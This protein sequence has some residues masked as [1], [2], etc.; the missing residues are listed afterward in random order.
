MI[1]F[2]RIGSRL[3]QKVRLAL[4]EKIRLEITYEGDEYKDGLIDAGVFAGSLISFDSAIKEANRVLNGEDS[5]IVTKVNADFEKKCFKVE[6][7]LAFTFLA[8]AR[9]LLGLDSHTPLQQV[10][11]AVGFIKNVANSNLGANLISGY[12]AY[13]LW[14]GGRTP[15]SVIKKEN[16]NM[17]ISFGEERKEVDVKVWFLE[18]KSKTFKKYFYKHIEAP[19]DLKYNVANDPE[20]VSITAKEKTNFRSES[21][22]DT[23]PPVVLTQRVELVVAAYDRKYKWRFFDGESTFTANIEDQIFWTSRVDK[24]EKWGKGDFFTVQM[25][26]EQFMENGQL[27][28]NNVIEKVIDTQSGSP[29]LS[30][31]IEP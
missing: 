29:L 25:R 7:E 31:H 22:D 20:G 15:T 27:K 21:I 14:S 16:G 3:V 2:R 30:D 24:G 17:E 11:S 6:L 1:F 5:L 18:W 4:V 23:P 19:G 10:L 13:K 12:I 26:Q 8:K 9:L 28:K